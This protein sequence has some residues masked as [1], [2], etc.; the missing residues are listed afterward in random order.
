MVY[1]IRKFLN[2]YLVQNNTK[3]DYVS[4]AGYDELTEFIN[5]MRYLERKFG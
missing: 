4:L 2:V 3:I 1:Y 5:Y